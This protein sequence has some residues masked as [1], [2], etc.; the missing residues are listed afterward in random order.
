MAGMVEMTAGPCMCNTIH[1]CMPCIKCQLSE[2]HS[3]YINPKHAC[4]EV[5]LQT[6]TACMDLHSF[7]QIPC[8]PSLLVNPHRL[9]NLAKVKTHLHWVPHLETRSTCVP[10]HRG[11]W[12]AGLHASIPLH[13]LRVEPCLGWHGLRAHH[14]M[15]CL[16]LGAT[17]TLVR[18]TVLS[19]CNHCATSMARYSVRECHRDFSCWGCRH[20]ICTPIAQHLVQHMP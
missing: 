10:R 2:H 18:A 3:C 5:V 15:E 20:G 6:W 12:V 1:A 19:T 8:Q 4:I 9:G 13:L 17:G 14:P 16:L 7:P 11:P